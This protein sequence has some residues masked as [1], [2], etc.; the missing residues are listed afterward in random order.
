MD[1]DEQQDE[2]VKNNIRFLK[3]D[4]ENN[5]EKERLLLQVDVDQMYSKH[6]TWSRY[7]EAGEDVLYRTETAQ[8]HCLP[9]M[10]S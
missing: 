10:K 1:N 7:V 2:I 3:V 4:A 6:V 8:T 5:G 9:E